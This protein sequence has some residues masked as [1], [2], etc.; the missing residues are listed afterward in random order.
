MR[1]TTAKRLRKYCVGLKADNEKVNVRRS[2]RQAKSMWKNDQRFKE[3]F[4]QYFK[5]GRDRFLASD[6]VVDIEP[7][8]QKK[9]QRGAGIGVI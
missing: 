7:T 6:A 5:T 4:I 1:G 2:Y 9:R 3:A 8:L